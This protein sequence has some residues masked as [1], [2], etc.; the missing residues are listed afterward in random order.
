[1]IVVDESS[2]S[3]YSKAGVLLLLAMNELAVFLASF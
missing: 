2:F 1:M 3:N